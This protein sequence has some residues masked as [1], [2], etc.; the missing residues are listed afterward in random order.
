MRSASVTPGATSSNGGDDLRGGA[1]NSGGG[2]NQDFLSVA[3]HYPWARAISHNKVPYYIKW[4]D[5]YYYY[6]LRAVQRLM[7]L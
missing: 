4:V 6:L 1:G 5:Y 7:G 3:V 2:G